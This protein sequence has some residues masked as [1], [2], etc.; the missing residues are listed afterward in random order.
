MGVLRMRPGIFLDEASW[1]VCGMRAILLNWAKIY[2]GY[3]MAWVCFWLRLTCTNIRYMLQLTCSL[4]PGRKSQL[5]IQRILTSSRASI[6]L[7]RVVDDASSIYLSG[8]QASQ[9]TRT[10]GAIEEDQMSYT[11]IDPKEFTF[12]QEVLMAPAYRR[13]KYRHLGREELLFHRRLTL[14]GMCRGELSLISLPSC[15]QCDQLLY[16]R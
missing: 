5:E 7:K 16:L 8:C 1:N 10:G 15:D 2:R 9:I 6:I 4:T 3:R 12:D 11:T 14:P 13:I